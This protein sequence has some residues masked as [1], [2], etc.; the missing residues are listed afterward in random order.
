M[1]TLWYEFPPLAE[2]LPGA[3]A[4]MFNAPARWTL[5][6]PTAWEPG[7]WRAIE[8]AEAAVEHLK[9]I[10]PKDRAIVFPWA[11]HLCFPPLPMKETLSEWREETYRRAVHALHGAED[12]WAK[13]YFEPFLK[14][15]KEGLPEGA[16]PTLVFD[17]ETGFRWEH[18]NARLR[19]EKT[20]TAERQSEATTQ[21]YRGILDQLARER[22]STPEEIQRRLASE[23]NETLRRQ[24]R[25]FARTLWEE[26]LA[27]NFGDNGT[28]RELAPNGWRMTPH[29]CVTENVSA[30]VF[31]LG[32]DRLLDTCL[33]FAAE[34]YRCDARSLPV[35]CLV[36]HC[37]Q[38]AD[39]LRRLAKGLVEIGYRRAWMFN[40]YTADVPNKPAE[41]AEHARCEVETARVVA[42][43]TG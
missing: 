3:T 16:G 27:V 43:A 13:E 22:D 15:V 33:D 37:G 20:L 18:V 8:D 4:G 17:N 40:G 36:G 1:L 12:T 19:C 10:A 39:V 25:D 28:D 41:R 5:P 2:A 29:D 11:C 34:A 23:P 42:E 26:C 9:P 14:R 6:S 21:V 31:Y 24:C 35:L 7:K 30:P 32:D 38:P